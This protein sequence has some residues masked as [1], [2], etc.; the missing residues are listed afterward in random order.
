MLGSLVAQRKKVEIF[1]W[2]EVEDSRWYPKKI[3]IPEAVGIIAPLL[4]FREGAAN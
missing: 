4:S 3:Q 2:K 1:I